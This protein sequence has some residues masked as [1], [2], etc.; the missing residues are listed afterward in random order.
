MC[1][2]PPSSK[3]ESAANICLYL[4]R[5]ER[6]VRAAPLR[7]AHL[8]VPEPISTGYDLS[9]RGAQARRGWRLDV[10]RGVSRLRECLRVPRQWHLW[11]RPLP[12]TDEPG[13]VR[14]HAARTSSEERRDRGSCV[15]V[16]AVRPFHDSMH[17]WA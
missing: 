16:R 8:T 17:K 10:G 11:W 6:G 9:P 7:Q 1:S 13:D 3:R 14:Q 2:G 15:Q 12:T 5:L 4:V